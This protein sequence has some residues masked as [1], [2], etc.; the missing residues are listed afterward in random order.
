[1]KERLK[2]QSSTINKNENEI[3]EVSE[4]SN[5]VDPTLTDECSHSDRVYDYFLDEL[6]EKQ[7]EEIENHLETCSSCQAVYRALERMTATLRRNPKKF[8]PA[9]ISA[10]PEKEPVPSEAEKSIGSC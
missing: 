8:F 5:V 1:M 6:E 4:T 2:M 10:E 7:I 9:E 3:N